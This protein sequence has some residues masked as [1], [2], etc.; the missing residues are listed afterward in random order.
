M[1]PVSSPAARRFLQRK[2]RNA[3]SRLGSSGAMNQAAGITSESGAEWKPGYII[4]AEP[5][6]GSGVPLIEVITVSSSSP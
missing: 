1:L 4:V 3:G 6:I 2:Q 5:G